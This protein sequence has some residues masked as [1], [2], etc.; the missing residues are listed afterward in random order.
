MQSLSSRRLF[1]SSRKY[2]ALFMIKYG[3]LPRS[4]EGTIRF[5]KYKILTDFSTAQ[6]RLFI[7]LFIYLL[8]YMFLFVCK[9]L[10]NWLMSI[11]I[12]CLFVRYWRMQYCKQFLDTERCQ[13]ILKMVQNK[14]Q[15]PAINVD[16]YPVEYDH[17]PSYGCRSEW[18]KPWLLMQACDLHHAL[19]EMRC[20]TWDTHHMVTASYPISLIDLINVAAN[21]TASTIAAGSVPAHICLTI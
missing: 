18:V 3:S 4:L 1:K 12:K 11:H 9:I 2:F 21:T 10:I 7:C 17:Y 5:F 19:H 15:S 16:M 8:V 13:S 14:Q 6:C 20:R